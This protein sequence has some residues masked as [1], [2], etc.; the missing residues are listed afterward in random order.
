LWGGDAGMRWANAKY[1]Q[2]QNAR[3]VAK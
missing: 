3:E 1:E 2:L